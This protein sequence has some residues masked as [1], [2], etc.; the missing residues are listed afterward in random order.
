M[1]LIKLKKS[2]VPGKLPQPGDLDFGE[3]A[4]NYADGQLYYKK[5]DGTVDVIGGG[6]G[7]LGTRTITEATAAGNQTIF[8]VSGGYTVGF[9]DVTINGS[10]LFSTD[11]T[12]TNGTTVVLTEAAIVG[13]SV[14]ITSYDPVSLAD[15]YR[16]AE[17]DQVA[18]DTAIVMAIALG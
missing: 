1:S 2:S 4:L 13:D 11:Y 6:G 14:R 10:Q 5:S 9:V 15:T 18:N 16:K 12:A 17:V 7:V 3:L 8:T